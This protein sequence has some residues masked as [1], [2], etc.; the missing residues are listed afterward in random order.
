M[1]L[2]IAFAFLAGAGT[3]VSPC[4]LPV[5]PVALS[6]GVTGGR[7][8]PLGVVSGL[9]LSFTFAT[10][11]LVYVISALGLP[12]GLL[13]TLAIVALIG[14]GGSLLIPRVGDRLEALLS[15]IAPRRSGAS[16]R[17]GFWSGMLVGGGLGFVYAP[18]AGPIL[19]GVI[20]VSA[21]QSFTAG[22][23]AVALA[24]GIGS[25]IVLYALMLGGRRLPS[26]LA[27]RSPRFQMGMGAS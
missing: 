11:A 16:S 22:G 19:A 6:A 10:V 17:E 3:A 7:R 21:S 27:Q 18:C 26:R 23:L 9:A 1:A 8:R 2:L 25:A 15:R 20:T 24:Y 5:L 4:V 14:F 13:R 12:N